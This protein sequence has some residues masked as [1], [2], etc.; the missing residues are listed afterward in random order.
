MPALP[1]ALQDLRD[2]FADR[3]PLELPAELP[4]MWNVYHCIPVKNTEPLLRTLNPQH[5][6]RA[7]ASVDLNWQKCTVKSNHCLLRVTFNLA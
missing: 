4:P 6:P 1:A 3:F 7:M 2:R 5:R